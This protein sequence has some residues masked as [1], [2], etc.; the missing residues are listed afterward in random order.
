VLV[1]LSVGGYFYHREQLAAI[2]AEHLRLVVTGPSSLQAGVA[3]EFS[4]SVT[5]I[6][7]QPLAA[8]IE[9]TLTGPDGEC[10]RAQQEPADERGRLQVAIPA[11]LRL[12]SRQT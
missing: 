9:V 3:A 10:L 1:A 6:S 5:A 7:G 4:I 2:A 11:N 12:P 8:Q